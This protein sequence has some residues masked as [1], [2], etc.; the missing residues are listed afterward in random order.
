[1]T[2]LQLLTKVVG[3]SCVGAKFEGFHPHPRAVTFDRVTG[4]GKKGN[5]DIVSFHD[6]DGN[7]IKRV[8]DFVDG[9]K[10]KIRK[11]KTWGKRENAEVTYEATAVN[12]KVKESV[13]RVLDK[14]EDDLIIY[15]EKLVNGKRGTKDYHKA[16]YYRVGQKPRE[17]SYI[18]KWDGKAPKI[19]Y[20]NIKGRMPEEGL[21]NL[22]LF[23]SEAAEPRYRHAARVQI[24]RYGL[25]GIAPDVKIVPF[26]CLNEGCRN[27][28][29]AEAK[30]GFSSFGA[31]NFIPPSGQVFVTR[32]MKNAEEIVSVMAH[33][34]RH[35]YDLS[36][37]ARL[38]FNV[39]QHLK[40]SKEDYQATKEI[41]PEVIDFIENSIAKGVI[42]KENSK[43]Q[44]YWYYKHLGKHFG[45]SEYKM[46]SV[47]EHNDNLVE[48]APLFEEKKEVEKFNSLID[49]FI[50]LLI[51][52]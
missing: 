48:L 12:G 31:T 36:Q 8:Y 24:N 39:D 5:F 20:K 34:Y 42:T 49:K 6:A 3:Q 28:Q 10:N 18:A 26:E 25:D 27:V 52:D 38:K 7:L 19:H 43:N 13:S 50:S 45:T 32:D 2:K 35:V 16:G 17:M 30:L 41:M 23:M 4:I 44:E 40:M 47:K 1:M 9:A 33:E 21:A 46:S 37:Y 11:I 15:E 51:Q 22:P 14:G 29:E